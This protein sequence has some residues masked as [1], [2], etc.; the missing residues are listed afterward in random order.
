MNQEEN[1]MTNKTQYGRFAINT[2]LVCRTINGDLHTWYDNMLRRL[3][4]KLK[5]V[6]ELR[7]REYE[8]LA[9]LVST[10]ENLEKR[11]D[12]KCLR[13]KERRDE[14]IERFGYSFGDMLSDFSTIGLEGAA[15]REEVYTDVKAYLFLPQHAG[16]YPKKL[17]EAYEEETLTETQ[18]LIEEN[19][20]KV[21]IFLARVASV[22]TTAD[23]YFL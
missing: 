13:L 6:R 12:E 7:K 21:A 5:V 16:A 23:N 17:L 20:N 19:G 14:L 2:D 4:L 15:N 1:K 8:D 9:E 18:E 10:V 11:A 3:D 22:I